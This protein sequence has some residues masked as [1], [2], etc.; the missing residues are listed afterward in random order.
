MHRSIA[1]PWSDILMLALMTMI[2]V[3]LSMTTEAQ[4]KVEGE[5]RIG[6]V[7]VQTSWPDA[8][9]DDID[10]WVQAPG[11]IPIG[12]SNLNG[13]VFNLLRDDLGNVIDLAA[14][15]Q[16]NAISRGCPAGEWIVNLHFYRRRI[17]SVPVPVVVQITVWDGK[18]SP[19]IVYTGKTGMLF[20]G[21]ETTVWRGQIDSK[22]NVVPGTVGSV[23]K[24]LRAGV[25]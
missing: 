17:S 21:Q 23:F 6:A 11:D 20:E 10:T 13:I 3:M 4:R 24:P 8:Y 1:V 16:E 7:M 12:Y 22:C 15:N 25:K 9:D 18:K 14:I 19:A 2:F 5:D